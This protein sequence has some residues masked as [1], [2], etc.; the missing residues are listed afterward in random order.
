MWLFENRFKLS[1]RRLTSNF[2]LQIVLQHRGRFVLNIQSLY[3]LWHVA[4]KY[5]SVSEY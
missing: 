1:K 4:G 3:D 2:Y 5:D